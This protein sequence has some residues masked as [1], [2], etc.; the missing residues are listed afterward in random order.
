M[1]VW[2]PSKIAFAGI[3]V[4][5]AF[6]VLVGVSIAGVAADEGEVLPGALFGLLAFG[7]PAA[8]AIVW[9][10]RCRIVCATDALEVVG[11]V[12]RPRIAW[13]EVVGSRPGYWGVQIHLRD[14]SVV[15][16][17]AVQKANVSV[18]MKWRTRADEL[19]E[20]I[21]SRASAG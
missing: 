6:M 3:Y 1:S 12:T 4:F 11:L 17:G 2:R 16:A 5:A 13:H 21:E 14:G 20:L 18:W 8:F 7:G 19:A 15:V 10:Q 9:V